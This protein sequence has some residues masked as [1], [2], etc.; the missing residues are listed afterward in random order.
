M[1]GTQRIDLRTQLRTE[2]FAQQLVERFRDLDVHRLLAALRAGG[3]AEVIRDG[4]TYP[5]EVLPSATLAS[6]KS[7]FSAAL[8]AAGKLLG[9][10]ILCHVYCSFGIR[11]PST[12]VMSRLAR[13]IGPDPGRE[14]RARRRHADGADRHYLTPTP[15]DNRLDT[16]GIMPHDAVVNDNVAPRRRRVRALTM[17]QRRSLQA[18]A[19]CAEKTVLRWMRG[20]TMKPAVRERL[21]AAAAKLGIA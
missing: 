9:G 21:D 7:H 14:D 5:P 20:E 1:A 16:S 19:A 3:D 18:E 10:R 15:G 8:G 6:E 13:K 17:H 11:V 4:Q 2:V 12:H